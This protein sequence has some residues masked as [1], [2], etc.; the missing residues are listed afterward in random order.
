M[1]KET[2]QTHPISKIEESWAL[3][4]TK[5]LFAQLQENP[6]CLFKQQ[7]SPLMI[8]RQTSHTP[9]LMLV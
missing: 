4:N 6:H 1:Q 5:K 3:V 7:I 9:P 2:L 8:L